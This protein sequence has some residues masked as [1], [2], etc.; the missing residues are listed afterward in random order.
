[1]PSI[2][3]QIIA[4]TI[5]SHKITE[6]DH[7]FS[8]LDIRPIAKGHTLIFPKKEIDVFFDLDTSLLSEILCFAKPISKAI[9]ACVDCNR[10]GL[11]VAGLE[12]PHAHLHLVPINDIT[13]LS[14]AYATPAEPDDLSKMANA[15]RNALSSH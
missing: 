10:I 4:G 8:C 12:V 14:F 13:K 3:S 9:E 1:M 7:F 5:P 11:M 2:F 6:N 15:I